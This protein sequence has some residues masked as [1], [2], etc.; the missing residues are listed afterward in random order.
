MAYAKK[1]KKMP[2]H[3]Y[4][5]QRNN[6]LLKRAKMLL[7]MYNIKLII[8][9]YN[10]LPKGPFILTPNHKSNIDPLIVLKA[11][12]K[13]TKEKDVQNKIPTFLAKKEL[14]KS[15][16]AMAA[17]TLNDG[18]LID[19]QNFREAIKSLK[20]FGDFVKENHTV[21]VVFPE[22][23]RIN[24]AKLGEF[25]EGAFKVAYNYYLPIVPLAISDTRDATNKKRRK[26]LIINVTFLPMIKPNTIISMEKGA[27]AKKVKNNIEEVLYNGH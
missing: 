3:H 4:P 2:E 9:G 22:G 18:V 16:L 13:Q 19:R 8:K 10:N 24:S 17:I 26:K 14:R 11:L 20:E 15:K 6:W 23:T 27:I 21:G 7:W 25:K 5:Q 12:E 1:Y